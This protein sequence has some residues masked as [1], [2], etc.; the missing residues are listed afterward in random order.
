MI[1]DEFELVI[2]FIGHLQVV[3]TSNFSAIATSQFLH[4][5][6]ARTE[7]PLSPVLLPFVW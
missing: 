3:T 7:S 4:S 5:T 2:G 6:A 1:I